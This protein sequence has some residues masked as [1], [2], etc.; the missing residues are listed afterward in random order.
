[1]H[2]VAEGNPSSIHAAGRAARK[3]V[4]DAR[5]TIAGI[6]A[7][8]P[9]EIVFTSG[10]TE[11]NNLAILGTVARGQHVI[12]TAVEHPSILE[13]CA[14]L[15]GCEVTRIRVDREGRV[16]PDDVAAAARRNTTLIS[17]MWGNNE[18]GTIQPVEEIA[19]IARERG[20]LFHVDAAQACGKVRL[21]RVG[22]LLTLSAHKMH[23]PPGV[24]ALV[25]RRGVRLRPRTFGGSQEF[26][27]RAGT[28][29]VA[30]IS[31]FAEALKRA[32]AELDGRVRRMARLGARLSQ[33]LAAIPD[34]RSNT[35]A[36]GALPHIVNVSFRGVDGEAIIMA[37]DAE[38][39][40]VS[41]GSACASQ[42]LEPSHVLVA[43]GLSP[44][45]A[46]GS[47]RFSL[48]AD[49]TEADVEG[50]LAVLPR[51]VERLRRISPV[52]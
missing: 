2:R 25:V 18:V 50:L 5:D 15:E 32:E 16:D 13:A 7:V 48:G 30:G 17:V 28:E 35:P 8:D 42:S 23:G 47:V 34:V 27:R 14:A 26:E 29:N 33:G 1:M 36:G 24:G 6:V 31:G 43:M 45:E 19:S 40:C 38:G 12:T 22:D 52:V 9:K 44:D 4:E 10:A 41:S 11:A 51:V 20:I 39:V 37:L 21:R 3:Q 46:R 49:S